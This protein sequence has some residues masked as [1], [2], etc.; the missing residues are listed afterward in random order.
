MEEDTGPGL[1]IARRWANSTTLAVEFGGHLDSTTIARVALCANDICDT[2]ARNVRIDLSGLV[3]VDDAGLLI[4]AA[5]CR[6]L[7]RN[8]C[9]LDL[10]GSRS[11]VEELLRRLFVAA[12]EEGE[13]L[14][15][16]FSDEADDG[17]V[18]L[19]PGER[20]ELELIERELLREEPYLAAMFAAFDGTACD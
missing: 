1:E 4:L 12:E 16:E 6:I 17:T 13:R 5:F 9:G 18:A 19:S 2:A 7:Q 8:G 10:L 20:H 14:G 15:V 11:L 3:T